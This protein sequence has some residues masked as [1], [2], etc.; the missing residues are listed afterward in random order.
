M[1]PKGGAGAHMSL[2][3]WNGRGLAE[4]PRM[5]LALAGKFPGDYHDLRHVDADNLAKIKADAHHL[6]FGHAK[7]EFANVAEVGHRLDANLGRLPVL[8]VPAQG[9]VGQSAAINYYVAAENG[10]MGVNH[11]EAA[12]ILAI[13]EHLTE[14]KTA[15]RNVIPYGSEPTADK[16]DTFFNESKAVDKSGA[17][18]RDHMS[19]RYLSWFL[20]RMEGQVGANGFAVGTKLSL[21]DVLIFQLFADVVPENMMPEGT[22]AYRREPFGSLDRTNKALAAHPKIEKIVNNV[23]NNANM[24][25]WLETRGKQSF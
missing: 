12:Q 20:G 10:M 6:S 25:K 22:P 18:V 8:E 14:L 24:K 7:T 19:Q 15:Y 3:Y 5:V 1:S 16:L 11:F 9:T 2:L 17:A 13:N 21:A 23:R 4:V